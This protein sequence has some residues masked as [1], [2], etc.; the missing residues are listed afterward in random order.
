MVDKIVPIESTETPYYDDYDENKN[1]YR[2]LFRPGFAVQARE[3]TQAQ[4]I[5][6][7]QI[8]RFGDHIFKNGSI[9]S[10]AQISVD[11]STAINLFSQYSNTDITITNF[12]RKYVNNVTN[13]ETTLS[14]AYVV[15]VEGG[16]SPV[17]M[18]NYITGDVFAN[19]TIKILNNEIDYAIVSGNQGIGS[20]ASI[21]EGVLYIEGFFVKVLAQT[22][23][24]DKYT[25]TPTCK[26][27][28]ELVKSIVTSSSDSSLLDPALEASNYQ[29][30]GATRYKLELVLA[31]RSIDSIDDSQF[32]ELLRIEDGVITKKIIYPQYS[33]LEKTLARRTFDESGSYTVRPFNILLRDH[34]NTTPNS[35]LFTATLSPGKAY[36][37]GYEFEPAGSTNLNLRRARAT[38]NVNNYPLTINYGH[39]VLGTQ[40]NSVGGATSTGLFKI[41]NSGIGPQLVDLHC[42]KVNSIDRAN[43][44]SYAATKIGT[45]R[46]SVVDFDSSSNTSDPR[47]Y[48]YRI[49]LF[50]EK[51]ANITGTIFSNTNS[52]IGVINVASVGNTTYSNTS[53]SYLGAI[54]RITTGPSSGNTRTILSYDQANRS[55]TL[56]GDALVVSAN[57]DRFSID[58][59]SKDLESLANVAVGT[60]VSLG[61]SANISNSGKVGGVD[62]GEAKIFDSNY[63]NY[64]FEFPE[65]FVKEGLSDQKYSYYKVLSTGQ[66][67]D[68][69]GVASGIAA[70]SGQIYATGPGALSDTQ[71]L[72]NFI[73]IVKDNK[74]TTSMANGSILNMTDGT[75][76]ITGDLTQAT[77]TGPISA[78]FTADILAKVTANSSTIINE[79][80]KIA[81]VSNSTH[82]LT[83]GGVANGVL[84]TSNVYL[85]IGQVHIKAPN[86]VPGSK[87]SLYVSD[88]YKL[89]KVYDLGAG[90]FVDN[91][92]LIANN[93]ITNR[94]KLDNGQRDT[95]YDHGG[96]ILLPGATPPSGNIV[97]CFSYFKHEQG[98]SDGLGYFSVDSY[99]TYANIPQYTSISSG[100]VHDLRDCI[101]FRPRR[102]DASNTSPGYTL[103]QFRIAL[104]N[105]SF[106][107][108][109]E[110]YLPRKDK[111]VLTKD[112]FFQVVEGTPSLN[113]QLPVEPENSMVL[114][115]LTIPPYTAYPAN[116]TV[117]YIENKRYTMR[118]IGSL[119]K[120]IENLE[121]FTYLNL[122]EKAA[123]ITSIKDADGFERVKNGI[124]VDTFKGHAVGDV[125]N[126]DYRCS[127]D[128][129]YEELRPESNTISHS[130]DYDLPNSSVVSYNSG[131]ITLPYTSNTFISQNLATQYVTV[132]PYLFAKFLGS[133]QLTPESDFYFDKNQLPDVNI[134]LAGE[135]DAY[136][137]LEAALN[138]DTSVFNTE[139]GHWETRSTGVEISTNSINQ[140]RFEGAQIWDLQIQRTTTTTTEN[141]VQSGIQ[142]RLS[143]DQITNT[144]GN[145]V[146]DLSIV[147]VIRAQDVDFSGLSFKPRKIVYYYF[148]D[149]NVTNYVQ[150]ANEIVFNGDMLFDMSNSE[151][152]TSGV[153][154]SAN[155]LLCRS[156]Q[157]SN[158]A[159]V[160][161]VTG[162]ILNGQLWTG[163]RSANTITVVSYNHYSGT[164]RGGTSNTINLALDASATEDYYIGNTIY[165]VAGSGLGESY[166]IDSYDG[167]TK[168]A[169]NNAGFTT[170]PTSNTRYSIGVH[171]TNENG[172][173]A[174]T[175]VVPSTPSVNFKTGERIFRILDA[176]SGSLQAST[177]SGDAKFSAQGLI[178][179]YEQ[180]VVSTRVPTLQRT[181]VTQERIVR[182]VVTSEQVVGTTVIDRFVDTSATDNRRDPLSQTF[183]IDK[184]IYPEGVFLSSVDLFF[185][186]KDSTGTI[187]VEV[188]IRPTVNGYPHSSMILPN[189]RVVVDS[190]KV[191][192]T[193]GTDEDLPNVANSA[194]ATTFTFPAPLYVPPGEFAMVVYSDS[195]EYEVFIAKLGEQIL[196]TDRLVSEQPYVGSFFK[197]QNSSTWTAIQDEDLMFVL[198]RCVFTANEL[199]TAVFSVRGPVSNTNMDAMYVRTDQLK[200]ASSSL[201]FY[202][203]S[204]PKSTGLLD[205]G[206]TSFITNKDYEFI[207]SNGRRRIN[208][209]G[210]LVVK[211][212]L[213]TSRSDVSPVLDTQRVGLFS[214]ENFINNANLSNGV[215]VVTNGGAGYNVLSPPT[216]TISG[217]GGSGA[218]AVANVVAV[219]TAVSNIGNIN[220]IFITSFGSGYS[221]APTVTISEITGTG[222]VN[223]TAIVIGENGSSGGNYLSRYI[224]RRVELAD[225]FD[226]GDLR[227][228]L[229][230]YKPSTTDIQV[231]YKVMNES[232]PDDFDNKNYVK[233]QQAT[234]STVYSTNTNEY[235]EYQ[236]RP[237]L[238][239][240]FINYT[241]GSTTYESFKYFAIKIVMSSTNTTI[242]PKIRD[243]RVIALPAG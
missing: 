126:I 204:T 161:D 145:R 128:T 174:G 165:F 28:L 141:Q 228:Y 180:T 17:I 43:P 241:V 118:D 225:G 155:V 216:V 116:V 131:I 29:A 65:N 26:V 90:I 223:A 146:V 150:K 198:K 144:L 189:G 186:A 88:V 214:I 212:E 50:D 74:G 110:Y 119:E 162:N 40:I 86:K 242:V 115:N 123:Q 100:T 130:L 202:Y 67:F 99:P 132:Q 102:L 45:A 138:K 62:S 152:I 217:G 97:V 182:D 171:K 213:R 221:E 177:T 191:K 184:Q 75:I 92:S 147:P 201:N 46:I 72:E 176:Q 58:F 127:I 124:L 2:I 9:V 87:D 193:S 14:T 106:S 96:I 243:L 69:S 32:I 215:I 183:F 107:A 232:D 60:P 219:N 237:S 11:K 1:F 39:Y 168:V 199:G 137:A 33:E 98:P 21:S 81:V 49:Y 151:R 170:M 211:A 112:R 172:Q 53:N 178:G 167:D 104:P 194:T 41:D 91:A 18:A 82:V 222:N 78:A 55:I 140:Q 30:P 94:Y 205:S 129:R 175:F 121:Y 111:I 224:T 158:I 89:D 231:Y 230:A 157:Y 229:T 179:T 47:T 203:K 196:G 238:T 68:A 85:N 6:Q 108:D 195:P 66:A 200:F 142:K 57:T 105:E 136:E 59:S 149:T 7:K 190:N 52:S 235:I 166:R 19:D 148:D 64:L 76:S 133:I 208:L 220:Q 236:F 31:K 159:Y 5:A 23:I 120:R 37:E 169:G 15:A 80:T 77:L 20:I 210:E 38:S 79:K 156:L 209:P 13:V 164:S 44:T 84:N 134:N 34:A 197:S 114:Y 125:K 163:A 10:G 101:D 93:D 240:D 117:K 51:Y 143:F 187:P 226:A 83:Q 192:V 42:V 73:V 227:V 48:N 109:Y 188:Q 61:G 27:G 36:V 239:K 25:I 160:S 63:T 207:D 173:I 24:L 54:F 206:Y 4:T 154:N 181:T 139:Y 113:P 70:G 8:E 153:A 12:N 135:N 3:L 71:V 185:A 95:H 16:A 234:L 218:I 122:L 22:I 233:M 35:Q 103:Q 56:D